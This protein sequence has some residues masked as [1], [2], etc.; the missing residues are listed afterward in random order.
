MGGLSI[1]SVTSLISAS[2]Q[3][4]KA[5]DALAGQSAKLLDGIKLTKK[6]SSVVNWRSICCRCTG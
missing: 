5:V 2:A 4:K 3:G 1:I 6:I